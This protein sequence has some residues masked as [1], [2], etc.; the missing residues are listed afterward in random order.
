VAGDDAGDRLPA[1]RGEVHADVAVV[2]GGITGV[3]AAYLLTE[4]GK[5]VALVELG[6]IGQGTTGLTTAKLTVGHNLVYRE[7][8]AS[9]GDEVARRY[10]DW[11]RDAI[12][13]IED[14]V[15]RLGIECGW[16]AASNYVYTESED[17]VAD[18]REEAEAARR[19]GVETE[20]TTE[21]ELPF[22]VEAALRVDGQAQFHPL[23][24]LRALAAH[25]AGDGCEVYEL[26]R[27]TGLERGETHT[28]R[29]ASGAVRARHV[30]LATQLP[31]LDRGLFFARAH[32]RK[33]TPGDGT[34]RSSA[35]SASTTAPTRCTAGRRTTT[36]R[37]TGCPTSGP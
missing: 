10:A 18:L 32:P 9:H 13:R 2:G 7:L 21:T 24:Y 5:R 27:A 36:S 11:N 12:D 34:R 35:S 37:W 25:V 29:T 17:R 14:T 26:T 19:A 1:L 28:V 31:F 20:L 8:A 15:R 33:A 16:E 22:P 6:R 4:A 30:V 3:T 23:Q